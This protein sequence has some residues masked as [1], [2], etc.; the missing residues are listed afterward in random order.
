[1]AGATAPRTATFFQA[2]WGNK[3]RHIGRTAIKGAAVTTPEEG[4]GARCESEGRALQERC[5]NE[6]GLRRCA[7][8]SQGLLTRLS[9]GRPTERDTHFPFRAIKGLARSR[10]DSV[11]DLKGCG[12]CDNGPPAALPCVDRPRCASSAGPEGQKMGAGEV[13]EVLKVACQE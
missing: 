2:T 10:F 4:S 11:G 9:Y 1:M 3:R 13:D 6:A 7:T 8:S 5:T 12:A